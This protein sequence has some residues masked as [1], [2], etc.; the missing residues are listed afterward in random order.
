MGFVVFGLSFQLAIASN[1]NDNE[2]NI[3][4]VVK[5]AAKPCM[6]K[7]LTI[8][9]MLRFHLKYKPSEEEGRLLD[10]QMIKIDHDYFCA[11]LNR[12]E[13]HEVSD[14]IGIMK[15]LLVK[16]YGYSPSDFT[17]KDQLSPAGS[18]FK[19]LIVNSALSLSTSSSPCFSDSPSTVSSS[20][21]SS[22]RY[23]FD[24]RNFSPSF[25]P[26]NGY[27]KTAKKYVDNTDIA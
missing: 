24:I 19:S 8:M 4:I 26:I 1:E 22:K 2:E 20:E 23:Y 21:S 11:R 10:E 25:S 9:A 3:T 16:K 13:K 6:V 5:E 18:P 12:P 27:K 14:T 17:N 7:G 15:S